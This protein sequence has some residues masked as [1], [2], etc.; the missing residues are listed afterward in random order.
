MTARTTTVEQ[1]QQGRRRL[2]TVLGMTAAAAVL[3]AS[4]AVGL[5]RGGSATTVRTTPDSTTI[6][7]HRPEELAPRGVPVERAAVSDQEMYQEWRQREALRGRPVDTTVV[8]DEEMYRQWQLWT[9]PDSLPV[10]SAIVSDA[11]LEH[12]SH[13]LTARVEA[14]TP[15][16]SSDV[17]VQVF[18][19]A[20]GCFT[21]R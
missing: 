2:R 21:E 12:R 14:V 7:S 13:A 3:V 17:A 1:G 4:A 16:T 18:C 19:G 11:E 8:S 9:A 6:G 10:D 5:S 15:F 20:G